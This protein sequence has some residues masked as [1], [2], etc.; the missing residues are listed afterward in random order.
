MAGKI[1]EVVFALI[2]V[3]V[4]LFPFGAEFQKWTL[5]ILGLGL[6]VHA[7]VCKRCSC[8]CEVEQETPKKSNKSRARKK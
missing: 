3:F 1:C 4:G 2:L 5:V 8:N 6:L 7:F